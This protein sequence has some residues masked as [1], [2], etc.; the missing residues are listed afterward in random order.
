MRVYILNKEVAATLLFLLFPLFAAFYLQDASEQLQAQTPFERLYPFSGI[1][2]PRAMK[3][4]PDGGYIIAGRRN[5]GGGFFGNSA[6]LTKKDSLGDTEWLEIY[7]ST[8]DDDDF[9]AVDCY[10]NGD[11]IACGS[12]P[13]L[14]F[15]YQF[16]AIKTNS[17]GD[18]L[19][20]RVWGGPDT[21]RARGV[22]ALDDGGAAVTGFYGDSAGIVVRLDN[23]GDTL[24]SQYFYGNHGISSYDISSTLDGGFAITGAYGR[25]NQNHTVHIVRMDSLGQVLWER[26]Y[27]Y[28]YDMGYSIK[29]LADGGFI[30]G[31]Y[32]WQDTSNY[33]S[34][35]LRLDA[36]GDTL[37]T[38]LYSAARENGI[39]EIVENPAGGFVFLENISISGREYD[40]ALVAIDSQGQF[41]WR[42]SYGGTGSEHTGGLVACSDGG[43]IFCGSSAIETGEVTLYVVKTD[44]L[45]LLWPTALPSEPALPNPIELRAYPN[46]FSEQLF[47]EFLEQAP[48]KDCHLV[49]YNLSGQRLWAGILPAGQKLWELPL[50]EIPLEEQALYI[51]ELSDGLHTLQVFQLLHR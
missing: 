49:L 18:T 3:A 37:W 33:D 14:G 39:K 10:P 22:V 9:Q 43:F 47:I 15:L 25:G 5:P 7:G 13:L 35:V 45:G 27:G 23:Q 28:Q 29:A 46:P 8:A 26:D 50:R 24:W 31:G 48:E 21:E 1:T 40:L 44:S 11:I 16:Y 41:L 51:L 42:R 4:S 12:L 30:V 2:V 36:Q 19:W 6:F 34:Y 20:S 32:S 17:L 38:G